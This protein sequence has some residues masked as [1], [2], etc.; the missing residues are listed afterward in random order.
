MNLRSEIGRFGLI[1]RIGRTLVRA[2][3]QRLPV[4]SPAPLSREEGTTQKVLRTLILKPMPE[5]GLDC[6]MCARL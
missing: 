6:L 4:S 1:E 3:G 5:S 2:C